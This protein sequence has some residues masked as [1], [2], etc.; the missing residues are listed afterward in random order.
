MGALTNRYETSTTRMVSNNTSLTEL[1]G[2]VIGIDLAEAS[3][4][5]EMMSAVYEASLAMM[6]RVVQPTLLDFLR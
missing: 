2:E 5:C 6:A 1:N 3:M 4:N